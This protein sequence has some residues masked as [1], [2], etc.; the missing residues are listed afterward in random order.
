[1]GILRNSRLGGLRYIPEAAR[2]ARAESS[3]REDCYHALGDGK[4]RVGGRLGNLRHGP[5]LR[6]KSV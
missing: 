2:S 4:V 1:L 6:E 3:Q 5:A